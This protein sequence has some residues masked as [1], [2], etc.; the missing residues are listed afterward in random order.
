M[1]ADTGRGR[2]LHEIETWIFDLDNTLYPHSC[3]LFLEIETR[4]A[5]FMCAEF[6]IDTAAAHAMRRHYFRTYGTTLRGLMNENGIDPHRFL[7]YVHA[8][9]VTPVQPAPEL[10]AALAALT[11]RKLVFTNADHRHAERVLERLGIADAFEGVF[12]IHAAEYLPKPDHGTYARFLQRFVVEPRGAAMVEDIAPNLVPAHALGMTTAWIPGGPD[13][14]RAEP[15]AAHIHHV[16]EDLAAWLAQIP[17]SRPKPR[18]INE[19]E[20]TSL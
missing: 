20:R 19:R 17:S 12:D 15:G 9:D 11:G 4:M 2:P 14:T 3:N 18:K 10:K 8:I 13:W 6:G 7:D 16:V 5:A 1:S